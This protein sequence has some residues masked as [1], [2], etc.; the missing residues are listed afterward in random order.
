MYYTSLF[1]SRILKITYY[2]FLRWHRLKHLPK[3]RSRYGLDNVKR[4][5]TLNRSELVSVFKLLTFNLKRLYVMQIYYCY[6]VV[7]RKWRLG[8]NISLSPDKGNTTAGVFKCRWKE[9]TYA[10]ARKVWS[11]QLRCCMDHSR[12][13]CFVFT[14]Y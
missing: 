6:I 7:T 10:G 4:K 9:N 13:L 1:L 3:L 12:H 2:D 8:D 5:W 14:V 11:G